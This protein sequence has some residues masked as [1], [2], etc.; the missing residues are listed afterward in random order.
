MPRRKSNHTTRYSIDLN[1][2]LYRHFKVK[3]AKQD[4]YMADVLRKLI[5][6]WLDDEVTLE[7]DSPPQEI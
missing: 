5:R 3:A 2:D 7:E 6:K 4:L 1:N